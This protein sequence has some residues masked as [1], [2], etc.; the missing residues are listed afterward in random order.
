MITCVRTINM[1]TVT[2]REAQ[3]HPA[4]VLNMVDEGERVIITRRG[5]KA[6]VIESYLEE[7]VRQR[8]VDWK[9]NIADIRRYL[10]QLPKLKGSTVEMLREGER[11]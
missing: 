9:K 5:N 6:Y 2:T 11:Y 3:H 1:K 7:D 8:K 10:R 4:K